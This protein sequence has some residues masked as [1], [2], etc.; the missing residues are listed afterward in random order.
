MEL[1]DHRFDG[2]VC[3]AQLG[4]GRD[5]FEM[6]DGGHGAVERLGEAVE[7]FHQLERGR[8]VAKRSE[9]SAGSFQELGDGWFDVRRSNAVERQRQTYIDKRIGVIH[10][11]RYQGSAARDAAARSGLASEE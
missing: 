2:V 11:H 9:V 5:R 4:C 6:P 3:G 7:L 10:P 1:A 8:R